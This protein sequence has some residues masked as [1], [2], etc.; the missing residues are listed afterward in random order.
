MTATPGAPGCRLSP[1]R[2]LVPALLLAALLAAAA[3]AQGASRL[4][5]TGAGFGHGIGMSQYGAYGY[6]KEGFGYRDILRRYY[7][8]TQLATLSPV[9]DVRVLLK[10]GT[11]AATFSGATLAGTRNLQAEKTYSVV[12]AGDGQV[13]LRSPTGRSLA[14]FAAPLR[15]AGP[16]RSAPLALRDLGSYR[17]ALE[18]YPSSSGGLDV[19]NALGLEDYVR[20]VISAESPSS[21]PAEALKAQAVAARTYAVTSNAGGKGGRFTQFADTR[22]QVY[23]GVSAEFATT[24]AAVAGTRHQ[25]VTHAGRP[26]TTFFFSTSG[27]R[28]ENNENSFIG[29]L[30]QPWLRSVKD[31][32][33]TSSPKHRWGPYRLS[34][35][36][37]ERKLSGYVRGSFKSI[38]VVK[39]GVSPRIVKAEIIGS[40]GKTVVDGP[41]LRARFDLF[42][43]WA[44]FTVVGSTARRHAPGE[45]TRAAS[46]R[47]GGAQP[48]AR[49]AAVR[50]VHSILGSVRPAPRGAWLKIQTRA[51]DGRWVTA[52]WTLIGR[53]GR[54]RSTLTRR[55]VYRAVFRGAVGPTVRIG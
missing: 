42:D 30:P 32:F 10:T 1:M 26:V 33:D 16:S 28:T 53:D 39:R 40:R 29:A 48:D 51:R 44:Y 5:I 54:Y 8:E 6:A 38:N 23:R 45:T 3:P 19:I 27:G 20:G 46:P 49:A 14:T 36:E 4:T 18:L 15:I 55:G 11:S 50:S 25:V 17:G 35:A 34:R 2:K 41:L 47:T 7:T 9:P 43:T 31:P 21:W 13:T 22:S 37:V 52:Q 12:S 24:D